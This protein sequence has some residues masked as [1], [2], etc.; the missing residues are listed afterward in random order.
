VTQTTPIHPL[1][2]HQHDPKHHPTRKKR[3]IEKKKEEK[4]R[5]EGPYDL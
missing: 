4:M 2:S 3:T 5:G 1:P